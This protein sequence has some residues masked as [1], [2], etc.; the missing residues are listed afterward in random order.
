[1]LDGNTTNGPGGGLFNE[2]TAYLTDG[3]LQNNMATIGGGCYNIGSISFLG[4]FTIDGNTSTAEGGAVRNDGIASLDNMNPPV[5]PG[6]PT[7]GGTISSNQ[8]GT[9]G[10]GI[11]NTGVISLQNVALDGNGAAADGGALWNNGSGDVTNG[12]LSRSTAGGNGAGV[13]ND[14]GS[15]LTNVTLAANSTA[16]GTGGGIWNDGVLLLTGSTVAGNGASAAG[17][18]SNNGT[19]S[20]ELRNTILA[21][22]TPQNCTGS[23]MSDGNNIDSGSTCTPT[24]A[25]DLPNA[26]PLLGPLQNNPPG[27]SF[28]ETRVPLAGSPAID[29][30]AGCPPPATDERGVARP[31]GAA[32]D[33]GAVEVSAVT[34]TTTLPSGEVC[35]NCMDDDGDGR[36]DYEDPACCT[37]SAA[38]RVKKV[39]I[40]PGPAGAMKGH[41]T[42][43]AILAQTAFADVDPTRDDVTVQLR[44]QNGELLCVNIS[45]QRWKR[46]RRRG[47]SVFGDPT[48][49]L[50]QGLRTMKITIPKNGSTRFTAAG[51]K[52]DLGRYARPELTATVRVGNRC[53]TGSVALRNR[54][55][56]KFV[57]P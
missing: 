10:G 43:A 2:G 55:K 15:N 18:T 39:V 24:V 14:G 27:P 50:A 41:L 25:G 51:K 31:Q 57:F 6:P 20:L 32:C 22:N 9:N 42:L 34:P 38:M 12:T 48:G 23:I 56:K 37:Q 40:V 30:A 28:L 49:A 44:N 13:W 19:G 29:A 54:G 45:H 3:V 16:S 35:G 11:Y 33:I 52:M 36:T 5:P 21:A 7:G 53:S 4:S 1:M 26:D 17:G 47:P 46:P 8:S